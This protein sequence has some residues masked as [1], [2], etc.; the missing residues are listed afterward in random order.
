MN[1]VLQNYDS[2]IDLVL[3]Y[4]R[5]DARAAIRALLEDRDFLTKE[6]EIASMAISPGY[7]RG[8]KPETLR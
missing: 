4:H 3:A 5:G 7:T 2:E 6:I 1:A 8:W